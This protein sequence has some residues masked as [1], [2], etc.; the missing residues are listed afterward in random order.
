MPWL[1]CSCYVLL[2]VKSGAHKL[3]KIVP[4]DSAETADSWVHQ[5]SQNMYVLYV[6]PCRMAAQYPQ[7]LAGWPGPY[8][9][10]S[11]Q[12]NRRQDNGMCSAA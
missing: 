1:Q 6:L 12:L 7:M 9:P 8:L 3:S 11:N 5:M 4:S 2:Y 10:Q